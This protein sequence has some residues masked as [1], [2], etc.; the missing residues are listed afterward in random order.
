MD[1][2]RTLDAVSNTTRLEDALSRFEAAR[3]KNERN[4]S[5]WA[6]AAKALRAL[7]R[8][9]EGLRRAEEGLTRDQLRA[10]RKGI[11]ATPTTE[12]EPS[13]AATPAADSGHGI[14]YRSGT[15]ITLTLYLNSPDLTVPDIKKTLQEAIDELDSGPSD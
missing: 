9:Q 15:G 3:K 8:A 12:P 14:T 2:G 13:A 6:N 10:M 11:E 4:L 7:G 1:V 5:A